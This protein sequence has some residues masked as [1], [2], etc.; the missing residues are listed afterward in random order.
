MIQDPEPDYRQ[1]CELIYTILQDRTSAITEYDLLRTYYLDLEQL[2][3]T[4][5]QDVEA[6]I[7]NFWNHMARCDNR[8]EARKIIGLQDPVDDQTIRKRYRQLVM[9]HHPG[10]GGDKLTIQ[11]INAAMADLNPKNTG[12]A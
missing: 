3:N 8:A 11:L 7:H 2:K 9:T 4:C 5:Q 6:L 12:Q 10:R 1:L